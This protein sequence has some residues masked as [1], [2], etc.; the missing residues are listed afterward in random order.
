MHRLDQGVGQ[1][2]LGALVLL[3][4]GAQAL[5]AGVQVVAA[6][7]DQPVRAE[8]HGLAGLQHDPRGGV[9]GVRVDAQGQPARRGPG[10]HRRVGHAD[11][12]LRVSGAGDLEDTGRGIDLRV[13]TGREAQVGGVRLADA[14]QEP[15]GAGEHGVG[16]VALGGV[17][18]QGY[19]Q[20]AHQPR[21]PYVVALDV[22][23]DQREPSS[24]GLR[25]GAPGQRDDV[26]PVAA[27]L[28]AAAG[29]D[30]T[31]GDTHAGD[32]GAELR[33]HRALESVGQRPLALRRAGAAQRLGQHPGHRG[34]HRALVGGERDRVG[35]RRQPGAHRAAGR[36]QR[37][38]RPG[39]T[40]EALGERPGEGV[41]GLVLLGGGDVDGPAGAHDLGGRV[42]RLQRHVERVVRARLVPVVADDRE[43]VA[44]HAEHR[45]P[46]R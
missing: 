42:V 18:A 45:E 14:V 5:A 17:G 2:L 7:L 24:P 43:L 31:R 40:P 33:H 29:G 19:A 41:A 8:H 15:G 34:E 3:E 22:A 6:G 46:V 20:L 4:D 13:Q 39:L 37:E 35:E 28:E 26:V 27:D 25:G 9:V 44:L 30:V 12:R 36:G 21:R 38:E 23:D 10:Q 11:H 32:A 16:P 1:F